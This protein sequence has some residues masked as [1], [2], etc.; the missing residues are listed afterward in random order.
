MWDNWTSL[1]VCVGCTLNTFFSLLQWC[2][3][4]LH[5]L[6]KKLNQLMM[7]ESSFIHSTH[8]L[9]TM[10]CWSGHCIVIDVFIITIRLFI[11]FMLS[12][13]LPFPFHAIIIL[14]THL[15]LCFSWLLLW[16][17]MHCSHCRFLKN[18]S[19]WQIHFT[20]QYILLT[21]FFLRIVSKCRNYNFLE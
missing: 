5:I 18:I 14:Y 21:N 15:N 10:I 4:F 2:A 11:S 1:G 13:H 19:L 16:S 7:T 8:N 6:K 17:F 9:V 3:A 12:R 20:L